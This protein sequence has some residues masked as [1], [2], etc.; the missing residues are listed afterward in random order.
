M[1]PSSD[2]ILRV[3]TVETPIA[4]SIFYGRELRIKYANEKM[5]DIWGKRDVIGKTLW[6]VVTD[7]KETHFA[8]IL[9]DVITKGIPFE[10]KQVAATYTRNGK[11]ETY[12]FDIEYKPIRDKDGNIFGLFQSAKD[13]TSEV[14]ALAQSEKK[15]QNLISEAT[16]GIVVI[17][18]EKLE[19]EIVNEAYAKLVNCK[20]EDLLHKPLFDVVA[21]EN[22][23]KFSELLHEVRLTGKP[24]Y[25]YGEEYFYMENGEQKSGYLN[26]IWQ[27]HRDESD[28]IVGIMC[29]IQ[30][31]TEQII[32]HK[33]IEEIVQVRTREL[34]ESNL[35]L[36]QFAHV[37]SHD[38]KE[39]VRK[40]KIYSTMLRNDQENVLSPG[41]LKHLERI[42]VA[43]HRMMK[44]IEGVLSYSVHS[45]NGNHTC[46]LVNLNE[47]VNKVLEDLE[48]LIQEKCA[49]IHLDSLPQVQG[50]ALLLHQV[51]YNLIINAIKF[52]KKDE[53]PII[54][55]RCQEQHQWYQIEITDNG[56]GF[57]QSDAE[58]IFISFTRLN[59]KDR[60]EGTGLGLTLCKQIIE[61]HGG[62]IKAQ[63]KIGVGSTFTILLPG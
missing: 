55:I 13:V 15:F 33:K 21:Q 16:V 47:I 9:D 42:D 56:I 59:S 60:Y 31:V 61:R 52:A 29:L 25:F 12:Y 28:N 37:A 6:E 1:N 20:V 34:A 48:L 3:L 7:L 35:A 40:M 14:R 36:S 10:G 53:P 5:L 54:S 8:Q 45:S 11:P 26:I 63:S 50:Y 43:T 44:M 17:V 57:N 19:I 32:A 51:F 62:T 38:L 49:I 39:P 2:E 41:S 27:P 58:E 30:D 4:S 46:E 24:K 22:D 18:G 23:V